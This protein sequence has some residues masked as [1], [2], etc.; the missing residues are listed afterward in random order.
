MLKSDNIKKKKKTTQNMH[1]LEKYIFFSYLL[2][3]FVQSF[4]KKKKKSEEKMFN[5][6][7]KILKNQTNIKVIIV[8]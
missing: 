3:M 5:K 2:F 8:F 6:E 4:S 7:K 1:N